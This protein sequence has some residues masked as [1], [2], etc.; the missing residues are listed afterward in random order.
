VVVAVA[1]LA[2]LAVSIYV[3]AV[4]TIFRLEPLGIR[5]IAVACLAGVAGVFGYELRK[6]FRRRADRQSTSQETKRI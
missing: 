3:P 6:L 5:D 4:A 1:A 2:A